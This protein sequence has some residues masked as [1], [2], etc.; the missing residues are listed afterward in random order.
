MEYLITIRDRVMRYCSA[1]AKQQPV[2]VEVNDDRVEM[3]CCQCSRILFAKS[4]AR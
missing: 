4:F 2:F 1:C 3:C